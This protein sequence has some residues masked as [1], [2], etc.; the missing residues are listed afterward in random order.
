[1]RLKSLKINRLDLI[2][3]GFLFLLLI[4]LQRSGTG[5]LNSIYILSALGLGMFL[6]LEK[7]QV[8]IKLIALLIP[9]SI[10]I[11]IPG[12]GAKLSIPSEG[13]ALM[14]VLF[15]LTY[16]FIKK[17]SSLR[18][19][20]TISK[21]LAV[22][23]AWTFICSILSSHP[24]VSFKR[25]IIKLVF[26][27]IF[28]YL[29]LEL[30]KKE[31]AKL[32]LLL[33]Y[34][35]GTL[36]V[37]YFTFALHAY[38]DFDPKVVF[39]I[40]QPYYND[41]TIYGACLAFLI[42]ILA[43]FIW[44]HKI[45]LQ[46]K[47]SIWFWLAVFLIVFLAFLFALSRAAWISIL[48]ALTFYGLIKAG[49]RFR[50][51]IILSVAACIGFFALKDQFLMYA[52]NNDSVSNDGDIQ[53][54]V[55][56]VTN[57]NSDASNLERINRW[58]CAIQMFKEKPLFGFGP[59]TYQFEYAVFQTSEYKTYISTTHG[60]RGNAHSEY[61]SALSESGVFGLLIFLTL[62]FYSIRICLKLW[63]KLSSPKEKWEVMAVLLGLITFY[64]HGLFNSFSDQDKMAFLLY[65]SLAVVAYYE[66]KRSEAELQKN[67]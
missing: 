29:P 58:N 45:F 17:N 59:G 10:G 26:V 28:F 54:H 27:V 14:L 62:V 46:R 51:V 52:E 20:S 25:L 44:Q 13:L 24:D 56:S 31:K 42:P 9:L 64:S 41:H 60:D 23:L 63:D 7:K 38:Y 66:N 49:M 33:L 4:P 39:S 50:G 53:N 43:I 37:I 12:T 47:N 67:S 32:K 8:L 18:L 19:K 2:I 40:C 21:I 35:L 30:M 55:E 34:A 22:D 6:I 65:C 11:E 15:V 16:H 5:L 61:L 36:P 3:L 57:L 1:M 48:I